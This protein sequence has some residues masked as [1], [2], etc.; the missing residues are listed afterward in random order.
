MKPWLK[1]GLKYGFLAGV[2]LLS[3]LGAFD[4]KDRFSAW[5]GPVTSLRADLVES[6][7]YMLRLDSIPIPGEGWLAAGAIDALGDEVLVATRRGQ[8]FLHRL[9]SADLVELSIPSPTDVEVLDANPYRCPKSGGDPRE[10]GR[11]SRSGTRVHVFPFANPATRRS[12]VGGW[13]FSRTG[14]CC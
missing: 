10:R 9:G 13:P 4:L 5:F 7:F 3:M 11:G 2:A 1:Y 14:P 12:R 6:T 8:F